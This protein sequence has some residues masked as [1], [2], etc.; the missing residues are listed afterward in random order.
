MSIQTFYPDG[1]VETV[2]EAVEV[3]APRI[4]G[5]INAERDARIEA[6]F[7]F[8]HSDEAYPVQTRP[9]D[10]ENISILGL[11]ASAAIGGGAQPGDYTWLDSASDFRFIMADNRVILM[12][13]FTMASLFRQAMVFKSAVTFH[14]RALKD[15]VLACQSEQ[16]IVAI[17]LGGGWPGEV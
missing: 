17:D 12:D 2:L 10:R 8:Y 3:V 4:I 15:A 14:A 9:S 11:T 13:A 6:G 7:T 1:E 5:A 16:E